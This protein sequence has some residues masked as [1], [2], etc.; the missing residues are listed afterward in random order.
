M[1]SRFCCAVFVL[2][3]IIGSA[4]LPSISF[5]GD[6]GKCC[7][8]P[9]CCVCGTSSANR[10]V[11]PRDT[12]DDAL[13]VVLQDLQSQRNALVRGVGV[14][15]TDVSPEIAESM[16]ILQ[17]VEKDLGISSAEAT[18]RD[19]SRASDRDLLMASTIAAEIFRILK[20]NGSGNQPGVN[21]ASDVVS[22][23]KTILGNSTAPAP[24]NPAAAPAPAIPAAAP[25]AKSDEDKLVDGLA[26]LSAS[27]DRLKQSNDDR[28]KKLGTL[29]EAL[30][31]ASE[32]LGA[33]AKDLK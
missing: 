6:C 12:I 21:I 22:A 20:A 30:E 32:K 5:A 24:V 3:G 8:K 25:A 14:R 17:K 29:K 13:K 4:L 16:R 28:A 33:T 7:R 18:S 15:G 26:A 2:S 1:Q 19:P 27:L 9:A 31:N 23:I 11:S 10:A